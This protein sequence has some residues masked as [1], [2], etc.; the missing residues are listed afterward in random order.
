MILDVSMMSNNVYIRIES[1]CTF[2]C[3]LKG[4]STI[5]INVIAYLRFRFPNVLS[6]EQE[7]AIQIAQINGI[8]INL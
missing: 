6:L 4:N 2:S 5:I 8:K 3:N 1:Q 7:L